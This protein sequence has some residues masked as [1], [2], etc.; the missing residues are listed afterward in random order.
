MDETVDGGLG[1]GFIRGWWLGRWVVDDAVGLGV[2]D[3][4][5][6]LLVGLFVVVLGDSAGLVT[7]AAPY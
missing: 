6:C 1:G 3:G 4:G 5:L 2:G 7:Y